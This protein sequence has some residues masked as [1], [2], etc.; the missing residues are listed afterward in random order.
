MEIT[1]L[2][3]LDIKIGDLVLLTDSSGDFYAGEIAEIT[4]GN[5]GFRSDTLFLFVHNKKFYYNGDYPFY[6]RLHPIRS[7]SLLLANEYYYNL[8]FQQKW[9]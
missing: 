4:N 9:I 5:I 6:F 3:Q 7:I 1:D 8:Y 2:E